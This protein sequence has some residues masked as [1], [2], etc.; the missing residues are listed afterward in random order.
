[1][2]VILLKNIKGFGDKGEVKEVSQGYLRNYLLPNKLAEIAS[3]KAIIRAEKE[4]INQIRKEKRD[5]IK[6]EKL[7]EK[8]DGRE[9]IIKSKANNQGKL[10]A[11]VGPLEIATALNKKGLKV[12]KSNIE[13]EPIKEI[14]SYEAIVNFNHGLEARVIVVIE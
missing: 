2:K 6:T 14:G 7:A 5:L 10:Y 11:A 9:I 13:I 1:M 4:R 8:V 3:E 12:A